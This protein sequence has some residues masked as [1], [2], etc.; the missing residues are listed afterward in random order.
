MPIKEII[1]ISAVIM[2]SVMAA[3]PTRP[4]EAIRELQFKILREVGRTDNWG[5][6]SIFRHKK[7]KTRSTSFTKR[8][9]LPQ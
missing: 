9:D 6:P 2:A 4:R 3:N 5:N 1:A 7:T 8:S